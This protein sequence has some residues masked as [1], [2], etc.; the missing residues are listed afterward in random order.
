MFPAHVWINGIGVCRNIVT[1]S[2]IYW[3]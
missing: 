3:P 1:L 2:V